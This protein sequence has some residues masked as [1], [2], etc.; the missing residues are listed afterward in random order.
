MIIKNTF[1]VILKILRK[2]YLA[3]YKESNFSGRNF[4]MFPM[5]DYANQMIYE[6]LM[7][8]D[9]CMISRFGQTEISCLVNYLG[10]SNKNSDKSIVGYIKGKTLPWWWNKSIIDQMSVWS[11]FFPKNIKSIEKFCQCIIQDLELIDILGSHMLEERFFVKNLINAKRIILEDLEPMFASKPWTL[12]LKGKNVLVIHPF[13]ETIEHQYQKRELLFNNN[14]LPEFNLIT[15]KAV[16]SVAENPT[17]FRDWFEALESM[18]VQ[19]KEIE[20]DICIIGCGAYGMP[21][22]AFVKKIGKKSI[23]LGGVTQ[24]LFGIK[25]RRWVDNPILYYPYINLFNEY[26]IYPLES[27]KPKDASKVEDACYW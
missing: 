22:A 1:F 19:I 16:Q 15:M 4:K 20:F 12:A 27:N 9:P 11:G 10:V 5:K 2:L 6:K 21:L 18:K 24:L 3:I 25:G 17:E 23:H 7:S 8:T 14:L 26:W 13:V